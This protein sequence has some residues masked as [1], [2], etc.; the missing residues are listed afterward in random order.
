MVAIRPRGV[1]ECRFGAG[2]AEKRD[3]CFDESAGF[4]AS[5]EQFAAELA[6]ALAHAAD[7]HT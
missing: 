4:G 3:S 2:S 1:S 5:D 7:T 6:N